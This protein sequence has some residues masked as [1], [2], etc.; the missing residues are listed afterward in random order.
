MFRYLT[1]RDVDHLAAVEAY[2][3]PLLQTLH[4]LDVIPRCAGERLGA[5]VA[6][7]LDIVGER[8]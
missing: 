7:S 1:T 3:P 6:R 5:E 8:K 2:A 4:R